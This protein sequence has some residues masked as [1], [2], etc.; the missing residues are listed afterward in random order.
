MDILVLVLGFVPTPVTLSLLES[1]L[2]GFPTSVNNWEVEVY[3]LS[4]RV[5]KS[6]SNI[7]PAFKTC[8]LMS[9]HICFDGFIYWLAYDSIK[10]A[11]RIKSNL[12]I[13]FD[14]KSHEFGEVCLP[15]RL[16]HTNELVVSKVYESLGLF[17]YYNDGETRFCDVWIMKEGVTKSFTKMLSIK[18][19][20]SW[21]R[22]RVLELRKN[23]E[24]IIE[25]IDDTNSSLL[26]VYDPSSGSI[27]GMGINGFSYS[28]LMNSYMETLLLLDESNSIIH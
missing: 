18:G 17:E 3:M 22:Y 14:L 21:V 25:N 24:A 4:T 11:D 20:D 26:E 7:P 9:R 1:I 2:F 23:G 5:W 15:D 8:G 12:I 27:S 28:F 6:M 16:V 13:S 19:L 10:L